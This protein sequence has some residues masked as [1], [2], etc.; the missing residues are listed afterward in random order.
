MLV[1]AGFIVTL[2]GGA[3]VVKPLAFLHVATRLQGGAILL[4]GF[5]VTA[6]SLLLPAGETRVGKV[7]SRL[8]EFAPAYQFSE[9]HAARIEASCPRTY[10]ALKATTAGEI[11]LFRTLTW[12]RRG[13]RPN[14][15][16]ILNAPEQQPLLDVATRTSFLLLAEEPGREYV[17]GT[18]VA[19][20]AGTR[21]KE[22]PTP[23]DYK[24]L[25][26][27]GF[28]KA[29]M[30]F[31]LEDAGPGACTVTTETRVYATD[32]ASRRRFAAY[33]RVIYPGSSL[34][35]A[36]WL[37]AIKRRAEAPQ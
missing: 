33:W 4:A 24:K 15:E 23:D 3:C 30:N 20:P 7:R 6:V 21:F 37:R 17:V 31:L 26:G 11:F 2:V 9:Y 13:G 18:V 25:G 8:D 27:P 36:M 34:I 12:I 5:V 22:M 19:A 14:K 32:A 28:A 29:S 35:R 1:Y 10:Q 16:S